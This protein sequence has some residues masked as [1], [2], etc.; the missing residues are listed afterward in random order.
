MFQAAS[1]LRLWSRV[2]EVIVVV[3]ETFFCHVLCKL[4]SWHWGGFE[5]GVYAGLIQCQRVE[6][7]EHSNIWKDRNVIFSMS[8]AVRGFIY[9]QGNM[10]V[11]TAVYNRF[12]ILSHTAV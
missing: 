9:Y 5:A 4:A 11:W 6:G 3:Y 1:P 12:G 7:G 2:A 10:E 8:V